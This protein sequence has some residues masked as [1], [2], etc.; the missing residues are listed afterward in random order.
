MLRRRRHPIL[1]VTLDWQAQVPKQIV[2]A[3]RDRHAADR[4]GS[5]LPLLSKRTRPRS[6]SS[7]RPSSS[8]SLRRWGARSSAA[9]QPRRANPMPALQVGA[10]NLC[11]SA[12]MSEVHS[13]PADPT[14][15]HVMQQLCEGRTQSPSL[16]A[17]GQRA[18]LAAGLGPTSTSRAD[19]GEHRA[20]AASLV[21]PF[22]IGRSLV[23]SC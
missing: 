2:L 20:S 11:A 22:P 4:T 23:H 5:T 15:R 6:R 14:V 18:E 8:R 17:S 16:D 1:I 7:S 12:S 3:S 13:H 21:N 10:R 9:Y 19:E